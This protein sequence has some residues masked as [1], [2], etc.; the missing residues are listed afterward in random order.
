M[1]Y[2]A[3]VMSRYQIREEPQKVVVVISAFDVPIFVLSTFVFL[4]VAY[5]VRNAFQQSDVWPR[6]FATIMVTVVLCNWLWIVGG[7]EE[8]EF[9]STTLTIREVLF[10]MARTKTFDM[11]DVKG[12]CFVPSRH[13]GMGGS[14]PSGIEFMSGDK[15]IIFCRGLT[16]PE[17]KEIVDAVVRYLP[18]L[19][20]IWGRYVD[21]SRPRRGYAFLD[22]K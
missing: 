19:A 16:S 21:V 12:P 10:G 2:R 14:R 9:T 11:A 17:A 7:K 15:E 8:V 18:D 3:Q 13:R 6:I 5:F 20:P 4:F 22:R 1:Y